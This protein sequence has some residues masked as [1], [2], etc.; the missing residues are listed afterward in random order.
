MK[1]S[2]Q[3]VLKQ[4]GGAV[5]FLESE[6]DFQIVAKRWFFD[7]GQYLLFQPADTCEPGPG[8]GGCKA[9]IDLVKQARANG[10]SAFGIVDRDVLLNDHNWL[11]WWQDQDAAFSCARPY[12]DHIR[13]LLRWELENYL[14]DPDAL[15]TITNDANMTSTHTPHSATASCLECASELKDRTAATVSAIAAKLIPPAAGFGC[16]NPHLRG[17]DLT[18]AL[19]RS[20]TKKGLTNVPAAIASARQQIDH[21]DA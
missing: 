6:E 13:V 9:V 3:L 4:R 18:A 15:A 7:E 11:L 21:F 19:H 17:E 2:D 1:Q 14:L 12:G 16:D 5:V 10:I 8:G 20:L